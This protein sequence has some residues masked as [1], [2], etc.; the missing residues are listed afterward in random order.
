MTARQIEALQKLR[1]I[2]DIAEIGARLCIDLECQA[3]P[4]E[5]KRLMDA[6]KQELHVL[7]AIYI[8]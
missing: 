7:R 8:D 3:D 6:A 5:L 2:V 4:Y 1:D